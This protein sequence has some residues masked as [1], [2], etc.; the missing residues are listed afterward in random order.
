MKKIFAVLLTIS[1]LAGLFTFPAYAEKSA[2]AEYL[3]KEKFLSMYGNKGFTYGDLSLWDYDEI[4]YHTSEETGETDWCLVFAC[5]YRSEQEYSPYE[6]YIVWQ[7]RLEGIEIHSVS[8]PIYN[9]F[10]TG[11]AVYDVEK[12][13]F[14]DIMQLTTSS[15]GEE[16]DWYGDD[17]YIGLKKKLLL[18][19]VNR[20]NEFADIDR[21]DRTTI[22]DVT[23]I[24]KN[25]AKLTSLEKESKILADANRDG[26]IDITDATAVQK[27]LAA[28]DI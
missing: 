23:Y 17:V 10:V 14:F 12:E 25:V 2:N 15:F 27:Y 9:P 8:D 22:N 24:Q 1:L 11:Y 4:Y 5:S 18:D 13:S 6:G 26:K 16:E 3:Y 20:Y 28:L 7:L 21:D 19:F